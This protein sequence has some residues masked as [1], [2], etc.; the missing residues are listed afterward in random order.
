MWKTFLSWDDTALRNWTYYEKLIKISGIIY[1][2]F[3]Q[4][5]LS[6]LYHNKWYWVVCSIFLVSSFISSCFTEKSFRNKSFGDDVTTSMWNYYKSKHYEFI[7]RGNFSG[8]AR[9]ECGR[10]MKTEKAKEKRE[11]ISALPLLFIAPVSLLERGI[12]LVPF[13]SFFACSFF[14]SSNMIAFTRTSFFRLNR[15]E[16]FRHNVVWYRRTGRHY[17][18]SV[19]YEFIM[20]EVIP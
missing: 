4:K 3:F 18:N 16:T 9:L 6:L 19:N 2:S 13:F 7:L 20:K 1:I 15:H 8:Q 10:K 11:V 5:W 17:Y 14:L 12:N